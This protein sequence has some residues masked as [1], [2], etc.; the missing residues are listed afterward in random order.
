MIEE[1]LALSCTVMHHHTC[2]YM[3]LQI[4]QT[5]LTLHDSIADATPPVFPYD[6]SY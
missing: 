1:K 4:L 3:T 6:C 2:L 5:V